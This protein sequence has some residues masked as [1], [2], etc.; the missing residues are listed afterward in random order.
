LTERRHI[1]LVEVDAVLRADHPN[2]SVQGQPL[3]QGI[4]CGLWAEFFLLLL[5][6]LYICLLF[7]GSLSGREESHPYMVKGVSR[8]GEGPTHARKMAKNKGTYAI[9]FEICSISALN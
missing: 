6:F 5:D 1:A 2:P 7:T 9:F 8:G 3:L 4:K